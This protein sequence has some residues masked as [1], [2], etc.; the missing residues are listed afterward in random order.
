MSQKKNNGSISAEQRP[1]NPRVAAI[2]KP[3]SV[4][5]GAEG[6]ARETGRPETPV[7]RA[8]REFREFMKKQMERRE[9][10]D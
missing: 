9:R 3:A 4:T 6:V 7:E 10:N 5:P 2:L 8:T 1:G